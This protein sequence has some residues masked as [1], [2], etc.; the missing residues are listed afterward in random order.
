MAELHGLREAL[1]PGLAREESCQCESR[2][3]LL[4]HDLRGGVAEVPLYLAQTQEPREE[5]RHG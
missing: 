4:S 5:I 1:G 3:P 2:R